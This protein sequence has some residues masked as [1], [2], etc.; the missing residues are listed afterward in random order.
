[1]NLCEKKIT[2]KKKYFEPQIDVSQKLFVK[3]WRIVSNGC[4]LRLRVS[5]GYA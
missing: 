1:M 3:K 5:Y 4:T 2:I